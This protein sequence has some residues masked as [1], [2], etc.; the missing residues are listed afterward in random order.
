MVSRV[1]RQ[2]V[3]AGCEVGEAFALVQVSED[4][5]GLGAGVEGSPS[6]A[7]GSAVGPDE[8]RHAVQGLG[9]QR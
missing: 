2:A 6:G 7:D 9:G 4:E 3:A 8:G 5:Q 1:R